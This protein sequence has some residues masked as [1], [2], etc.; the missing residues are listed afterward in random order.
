MTGIKTKVGAVATLAALGG[1]TAYAA[2]SG[3]E[4][5]AASPAAKRT[6]VEVR[7]ETIRRTVHVVKHEKRRGGEAETETHRRGGR[8]PGRAPAPASVVP[9]RTI[10][11]PA[12]VGRRDDDSGRRG[13]DD[14][15]AREHEA[16]HEHEVEDEH[17]VEHERG[18]G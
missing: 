8:G 5:T 18:D 12:P 6:P 9:A 3:D 2:G 4:G 10:S 16:E 1:L 17:E 7:T 13:G 11:A 14:D 15:H